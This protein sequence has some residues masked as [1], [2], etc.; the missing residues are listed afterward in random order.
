MKTATLTFAAGGMGS[1]L[2]KHFVER[3]ISVIWAL[4][5]FNGLPW[6]GISIVPIP[7]SL[8]QLLAMSA[9]GIAALLAM[10][11]NR[12]LLVRPNF[13]LLLFLLLAATGLV[14]GVRGTA[15]LGAIA[16]SMRLFAFLGVLWLLTPWWGRR[17]LLLARC[18][19]RALLGVSATVIVGLL[20]APTA[21]LG[22]GGRLAGVI[23]PLWPTAVG[24]VAGVSAGMAAVLWLSHSIASKRAVAIG[25]LGIALLLLSQTRTALLALVGGLLCA[26]LSLFIARRRVRRAIAV[27]LVL[28]PMAAMALA[29][30]FA[31]WFARGQSTEQLRGLTG[32]KH[33]WTML[34]NTPRSEF[35][36]WFGFGFS[37]RGFA[38]LPIDNSW[39]SVYHDQGIIGVTIVG[40]VVLFLL[41]APAF[42]VA[43]TSRSLAIFL[44][45][46]CAIES[47]TEV[48]LGDASP[49]LLELTVAASLLQ[50]RSESEDDGLSAEV[51]T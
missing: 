45:V 23:W 14:A 12:R 20:V 2:A 15:G 4:L 50:T 25:L 7:Q 40:T 10:D 49:Y 41:L 47:Y 17:D 48:G 46:Y 9:L 31:T 32:R 35:N 29:P 21:A 27:V 3:R 42:R 5:L 37:D 30:A 11:L 19:L 28:V 36:Q 38:G 34:L 26:A 24:H 39:L 16:R 22:I 13:V 8:G 43:A 33:V 44:V 18:H 1:N 51:P 6:M